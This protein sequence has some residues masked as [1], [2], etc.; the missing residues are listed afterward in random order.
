M[1]I[2]YECAACLLV[3]LIGG[4]LLFAAGATCVLLWGAGGIAW[5]WWRELSLRAN[6]LM[7]R[8]TAEPREPYSRWQSL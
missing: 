7:G 8:W 4:M 6:W 5:R 1:C 2:I 3:A